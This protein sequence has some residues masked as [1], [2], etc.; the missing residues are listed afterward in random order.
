MKSQPTQTGARL[1]LTD[2]IPFGKYRGARIIDIAISDLSYLKWLNK[3]NSNLFAEDVLWIVSERLK[4]ILKV[5]IV[6]NPA[7]I[8]VEQLN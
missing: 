6:E 3:S 8:P 4:V 5:E 1:K 2:N 7:Y